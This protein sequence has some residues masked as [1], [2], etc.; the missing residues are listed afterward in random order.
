MEHSHTLTHSGHR[1]QGWSVAHEAVTGSVQQTQS[2][3]QGA[4]NHCCDAIFVM[5]SRAD[6]ALWG[7]CQW[8][9]LAM[10][11]ST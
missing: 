3:H 10:L 2:C 8:S 6:V 9:A 5:F 1:A 7:R 11:L 4:V